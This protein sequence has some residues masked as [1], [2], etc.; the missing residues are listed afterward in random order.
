M[1][2]FFVLS[3]LFFYEFLIFSTLPSARDNGMALCDK[4]LELTFAGHGEPSNTLT[5]TLGACR[6]PEYP[7]PSPGPF[8]VQLSI[9][10][11]WLALLAA[12][13]FTPGTLGGPKPLCQPRRATTPPLASAPSPALVSLRDLVRR[14]TNTTKLA[15]GADEQTSC[16]TK[17]RLFFGPSCQG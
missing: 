6:S 8:C 3:M 2:C 10:M 17:D 14:E 1:P 11:P 5:P 12:A 16:Q 9:S 15:L 13:A 7:S 4:G